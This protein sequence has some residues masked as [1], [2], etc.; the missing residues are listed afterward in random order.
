LRNLFSVRDISDEGRSVSS[1]LDE[2]ILPP[3]LFFECRSNDTTCHCSC[4]QKIKN[5]IFLF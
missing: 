3:F 2:K 5:K 1:Y 4:T